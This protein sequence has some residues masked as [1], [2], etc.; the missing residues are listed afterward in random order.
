MTA[1][2]NHKLLQVEGLTVE[3]DAGKPTAHRALDGVSLSI[4]EGESLALVGESGSGK[5]VLARTILGIQPPRASIRSR[6]MQWRGEDMNAFSSSRRQQWRRDSVA[7][8]WQNPQASLVPVYSI[9]K[10]MHWLLK[11]QGEQSRPA[12]EKRIH[13]LL[14][15]VGLRDPERISHQ[16]P[17]NLSGGECQR[18]MVAMAL[19]RKPQILIADEPTSNLD[20]KLQAEILAL[21]QSIASELQFAM[22]FITHD[23]VIAS[24]LSTK[25]AVLYRGKLVEEGRTDQVFRNP[26]SAYTKTLIES[27]TLHS[28]MNN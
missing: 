1:N 15:H 3:F 19:S 9:G 2:S 25:T 12:R 8:I 23:L 17:E 13:E 21:I 27:A 24:R 14:E 18:I 28:H 7:V 26:Q 11:L 10:Q 4:G 22:L 16:L 20:V 6:E 5:T